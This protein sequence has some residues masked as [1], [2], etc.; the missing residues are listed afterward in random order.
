MTKATA[1]NK[2]AKNTLHLDT[3]KTHN[4]D[5]LDFPEHVAVWQMKEALEAAY[6]AGKNSAEEHFAY[7]PQE[8]E[9]KAKEMKAVSYEKKVY[10]V[11]AESYL[12]DKRLYTLESRNPHGSFFSVFKSD[13]FEVVWSKRLCK[14]VSI[15]E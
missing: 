13:C 9:K 11:K 8:E 5:R 7:D 10:V 6:E 2:I 1:I 15:P 4:S 14:Y 12:D 3:L